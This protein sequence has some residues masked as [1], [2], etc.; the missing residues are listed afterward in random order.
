MSVPAGL[1]IDSNLATV[2]WLS[3]LLTKAGFVIQEAHRGREGL[4]KV[5][6]NRPDLVVLDL[7]LPDMDVWQFANKFVPI[8]ILMPSGSWF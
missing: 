8:V 2:K 3:D 5:N 4:E 7:D 1:I 6:R